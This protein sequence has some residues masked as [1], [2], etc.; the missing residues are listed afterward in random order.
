MKIVFCVSEDN[1]SGTYFRIHGLA[2]ALS[3]RGHQVTVVSQ[4]STRNMA[5]TEEDRDGIR[6]E[7]APSFS[8]PRYVPNTVNPVN[9]A[10]RSLQRLPEADIC[11]LFQPFLPG[12]ISWWK[13]R[14]RR[15]K[16][17]LIYDWDD[18]W[19]NDWEQHL[20]RTRAIGGMMK[21]LGV[22]IRNRLE[23]RFPAL[24]DGVTVVSRELAKMAADRGAKRVHL[25]PV[26]ASR[27]PV[28][29]K[30]QA[31]NRLKLSQTQFLLGFAG[32]T[33]TSV[34]W[35]VA[36]LERV[37]TFLPNSS[38]AFCGANPSSL[39]F[40][41]QMEDGSIHYLG[42]LSKADCEMFC[43]AVDVLL[44]PLQDIDVHR[45]GFAG[46][47]GEYAASGTPVLCSAVGECARV[48]P[49]FAQIVPAPP[50]L[51]GWL[52]A[53]EK[54]VREV[55]SGQR[56]RVRGN[57]DLG[58]MDWATIGYNLEIFY[59]SSIRETLAARTS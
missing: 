11:H 42:I 5:W 49:G 46:K 53:G 16:P 38:I 7:P 19:W 58:E 1:R 21:R 43:Q 13:A 47:F 28:Y 37:R 54:M 2:V 32:W 9:L 31:R 57:I 34:H 17:V 10:I 50:T 44:L 48:I 18:I 23:Q 26:G 3:K 45:C 14:F 36:L 35:C 27:P 33:L 40:Q 59:T 39:G 15:P 24:A 51:E 56:E 22:R 12:F 20:Y 6:Y 25:V 4:H 8:A 52:E 30:S 29:D 41:K 55:I